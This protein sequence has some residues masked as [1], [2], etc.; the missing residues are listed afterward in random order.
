MSKEFINNEFLGNI[1]PAQANGFRTISKDGLKKTE[2]ESKYFESTPTVWSNAFAFDRKIEGGDSQ[3]IEEWVSLFVLHY[4][5]ILHLREIKETDLREKY[6]KDLWLAL[7]GTYLKPENMSDLTDLYLLETSDGTVVGAYHPRNIF[8]PARGRE[9]WSENSILQPFLD[10]NNQLS[11]RKCSALGETDEKRRFCY[12]HLLGVSHLLLDIRHQT[13]LE[14]FCHREFSDFQYQES[15]IP[16]LDQHPKNWF[17]DDFLPDEVLQSYPLKKKNISGG[18]TY[19]LVNEMPFPTEWM[20]KGFP[21][22]VNF[23]QTQVGG[24][25]LTVK[26]G[27]RKIEIRLEQNDEIVSLSNLLLK[28]PSFCKLKIDD[29]AFVNHSIYPHQVFLRDRSI[30]V[31]ETAICLAPFTEEFIQNFPEIYKAVADIKSEYLENLIRWTFQL[32]SFEIIWDSHPVA[33]VSLSNTTL[34]VFPPKVSPDWRLYAA[35]GTGERGHGHWHLLDEKGL[36]GDFIDLTEQRYISLLHVGKRL[37][38][39]A[40]PADSQNIPGNIPRA[41]LYTDEKNHECGILIFAP[42]DIRNTGESENAKLAVDFGTSNTSLG[43]ETQ[44]VSDILKF[45]LSPKPLWGNWVLS[46]VEVAGT[47]PHQWGGEKGFFPTNLL[48]RQDDEV[49]QQITPNLIDLKHL[50]RVD[51]PGLHRGLNRLLLAGNLT[52]QTKENPRPWV[53]HKNLKWVVDPNTPWRSLFL[54]LVLVYAHAEVFFTLHSKISK[55]IFTQPLA[56]FREESESYERSVKQAIRNVRHYCY[57]EDRAHSQFDYVPLDE[58]SAIAKSVQREDGM[59]GL[60]EVFIDIGGGTTD[61]AVRH[62]NSYLVLDSVK[63]GGNYFSGVVEKTLR[64]K[65]SGY[66]KLGENLKNLLNYDLQNRSS[67]LNLLFGQAYSITISDLDN[68]TFKRREESIFEKGMGTDS[69]S[70]FRARLFFRHLMAYSLLQAVAA[71]IS[72]KIDLGNGIDLILGGNGWGFLLFGEWKRK[73]EFLKDKADHIL[74]L[75]KKD[76]EALVTPEE[77]ELLEKMHINSVDLLNQDELSNA[78]TGV[79]RGA[80]RGESQIDYLT[81]APFAGINIEELQINNLKPK[82]IRW[83]DRWSLQ[84]FNNLFGK[85]AGVEIDS[86]SSRSFKQPDN[87]S[88]PL[89]KILKVFMSLGGKNVGQD[90]TPGEIWQKINNQLINCLNNITAE[91]G[92]LVKRESGPNNHNGLVSC[93]PSN[94]FLSMILYRGELET[95]FLDRLAEFKDH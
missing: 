39:P 72:H 29:K 70:A 82:K 36:R 32:G 53:L 84:N 30:R 68:E 71:A 45:T 37:E 10:E 21:A 56:F 26:V 63:I 44:E 86:I 77:K 81:T 55:Y 49:L 9:R 42:F 8:F 89:D 27:N 95:N 3:A 35:Y 52:T 2:Y 22:P 83:C 91:G 64:D 74:N 38:N 50:F 73:N 80:L 46:D 62:G 18:M 11:W 94:Y 78:K 23:S 19:Y 54:E 47:I 34:E 5:R 14:A 79:V 17:G 58:S 12:H 59:K 13:H 51:I 67:E 4:H 43:F 85:D 88:E 66:G 40:L 87:L 20:V 93:V 24:K 90:N 28:E 60:L 65:R 69:F 48:S 16:S 61:I 57:G 1:L 7:S 25:S 41:A 75:L 33:Q 31:G 76:L 92:E 6:D 15:N